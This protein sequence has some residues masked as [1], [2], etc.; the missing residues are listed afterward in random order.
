M[1]GNSSR[2][3]WVLKVTWPQGKA[4]AT[5]ARRFLFT[6]E[7][8]RQEIPMPCGCSQAVECSACLQAASEKADIRC[9]THTSAVATVEIRRLKA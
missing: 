2:P 3:R 1:A 5:A 8:L 4:A 6:E 7:D 9:K